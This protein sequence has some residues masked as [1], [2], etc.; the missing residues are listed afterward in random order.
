MNVV[1]FSKPHFYLKLGGVFFSHFAK[2]WIR[3]NVR[4]SFVYYFI[5]KK[6]INNINNEQ[7]ILVMLTS[8]VLMLIILLILFV[9]LVYGYHRQKYD[10]YYLR[11]TTEPM[12]RKISILPQSW[13]NDIGIVLFFISFFFW[14]TCIILKAD[15]P[16]VNL[17]TDQILTIFLGIMYS[18][19]IFKAESRIYCLKKFIE[20]FKKSL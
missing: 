8:S 10:Q 14:I 20:I 3:L 1:H 7:I 19:W 12:W 15:L 16:K 9:G 13:C 5:I 6:E 11:L 2:N 17:S 18:D 4:H